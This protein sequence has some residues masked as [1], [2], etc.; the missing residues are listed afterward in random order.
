MALSPQAGQVDLQ[1]NNQ[2]LPVLP[3][4]LLLEIIS[5]F[6]AVDPL[7]SDEISS[8]SD[9]LNPPTPRRFERRDAFI[10]LAQTCRRLR[11]VFRPLIWERIEVRRGMTVGQPPRVLEHARLRA[12][13]QDFLK[14]LLRQLG[15]ATADPI[16][17][18][19]VR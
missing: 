4:E 3:D 11:R 13:K 15:V 6:E 16:L 14:E 17:A 18:Q 2:F 5:H 10:A 19:C 1:E 8:P 7:A 12:Q 9:A